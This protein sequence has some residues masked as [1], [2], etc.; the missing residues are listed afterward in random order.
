M[1]VAEH[2]TVRDLL[3]ELYPVSGVQGC[4]WTTIHGTHLD[5]PTSTRLLFSTSLCEGLTIEAKPHSRAFYPHSDP[6]AAIAL[7]SFD[8]MDAWLYMLR[9]LSG[10]ERWTVQPS[11]RWGIAGFQKVVKVVW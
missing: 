1:R 6:S 2:Q 11:G 5:N 9:R 4:L 8:G 3:E 10:D 7:P